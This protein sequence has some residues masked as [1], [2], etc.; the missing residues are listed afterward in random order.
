MNVQY[1]I[2]HAMTY[3]E[4][5]AFKEAESSTK[6]G[7]PHGTNTEE[8]NP[9]LF[10]DEPFGN[11]SIALLSVVGP[12]MKQKHQDGGMYMKI[13]TVCNSMDEASRMAK[14]V[15]QEQTDVYCVELFKF[16]CM[17]PP[18]GVT[19]QGEADDVMNA[20]L[21]AYIDGFDKKEEDF[22]ERK[23]KMLDDIKRQEDMKEKIRQGG[24]QPED[25]DSSSVCPEP[26]TEKV[27]VPKTN[28]MTSDTPLTPERYAVLCTAD[29]SDIDCPLRDHV[30]FKLC[31]VHETEE[32]ASKQLHELKKESRYKPYDISLVH[33]YEWLKMPPPV[34][35]LENVT[36]SSAKLTD[37]LGERKKTIN[38]N[39]T[40]L[41]EPYEE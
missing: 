40:A 5:M 36:Y 10:E 8:K 14:V 30:M 37:V 41:Q 32:K 18:P 11:R 28:I 1:D 12:K 24:A 29:L 20:C 17:P 21:K 9:Y 2:G 25:L 16:S 38:V 33:L 39:Q 13:K 34:E 26:I 31:G 6:A 23:Q 19:T 3:E 35:I 7:L 4:M 15:P 27:D 22:N